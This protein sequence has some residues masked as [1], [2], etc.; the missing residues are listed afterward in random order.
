MYM[1][2]LWLPISDTEL[3]ELLD[4]V[5]PVGDEHEVH[6]STTQAEKRLLPFYEGVML[7]RIK[8]PAWQPRNLFIYYLKHEGQLYWLNGT[9]PPIHDLNTHDVLRLNEGT[10]LDYLRFFNFFVRGEEGPFLVAES[11]ED[12]YVPKDID[13]NTRTALM[14]CVR[15]AHLEGQ[16]ENGDWIC[17]ATI[18][19]SNAVFMANFV[20]KQDGLVEMLDDEPILADLPIKVFAPVS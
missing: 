16:N 14:N 6:P 15:P 12:T 9:S 19:Y 10:V 18:Y 8:E 11:M 7:I 1:D 13:A 2:E 17:D 3:V 5:G 20:I 4:A